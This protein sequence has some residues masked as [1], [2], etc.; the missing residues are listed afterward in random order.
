VRIDFSSRRFCFLFKPE[1]EFH[2]EFFELSQCQRPNFP[3]LVRPSTSLLCGSVVA[4]PPDD[5]DIHELIR[6]FPALFSDTLGNV[7]GM[8]CHLD[9]SDNNPVRLRP[10]QCSPPRIRLL[11]EI[12]QELIEKGL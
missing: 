4:R 8:A 10:Y 3:C 11:R 1:R 7:K 5:T 9:L 6:G 12:V 2:F